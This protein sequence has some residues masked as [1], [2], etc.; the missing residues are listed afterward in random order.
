MGN[1]AGGMDDVDLMR[2]RA[3][4]LFARLL[5]RA[6]DGP[7]LRDLAAVAGDATPF[8]IALTDVGRAARS[9]TTAAVAREFQDLFIGVTRGELVPYAS[10]YL[11][12][13]LFDRPLARLRADLARIGVVKAPD[14]VEPEDHIA[15]LLDAMAG[16]VAGSLGRDSGPDAQ[17]DLFERHLAPWAGRFFSDLESAPSARLYA[18]V[19]RLGRLFI[20]IETRAFAMAPA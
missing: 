4:A 18:P 12:G 7:L 19:G 16:L 2:A 3:Y 13:F 10:F 6:P 14:V 9:A 11:S 15:A 20:V 8:G 1:D 5:V 17:R